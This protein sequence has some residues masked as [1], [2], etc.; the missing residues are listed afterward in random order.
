MTA[1][2]G[3]VIIKK[4]AFRNMI[5][6]VLR[7]GN[8]AIESVEVMGILIGKIAANGDIEIINAIPVKHGPQC[9][10]GFSQKDYEIFNK[11]EQKFATQNLNEI[12]GWYYSHPGWGLFFSDIA[13]KNHPYFQN[14]KK[15]HS[16]IIVF[17]YT[18]MGKKNNLGF[19]IYRLNDYTEGKDYSKVEYEVE[20]PN[21]LDYFKWVQKFVEDTQKESPILIK[22]IN[23]LSEP[24]P[25]DLQEIPQPEEEKIK[26]KDEFS[27][28]IP[29]IT[30]FQEGFSKFSDL[31]MD[32]FKNQFGTWTNDVKDGTLNGSELLRST[33]SRMKS[34]ISDGISK[35][36]KW[37]DTNLNELI[38][39][40]KNDTTSLIDD[41]NIVQ[42]N[43][44]TNISQTKE[45]VI[46]NLNNLIENQLKIGVTQ[47]E[48]K[49]EMFSN[50]IEKISNLSSNI[51]KKINE[52]KNK[53]PSIKANLEDRLNQIENAISSTTSSFNQIIKENIELLNKELKDIKDSFV[54]VN[55]NFQKLQ[56]TVKFN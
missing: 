24:T 51:T 52:I 41:K 11:I 1:I 56:K 30:N 32:T 13:I 34:K 23:E 4:E 7:F 22:E 42:N 20:L 33:T 26:E 48:S 55:Q 53:T 12:V 18:L 37:F 9:S 16:I 45:K 35:I 8:V 43:L 5:T 19:E 29:I 50:K 47:F 44:L 17:D 2:E 14:D 38:N 28:V 39:K 49:V 15:P 21:S 46:E 54:K 31:F 3:K 27:S 36:Q 25:K 40:F 6:H 10:L